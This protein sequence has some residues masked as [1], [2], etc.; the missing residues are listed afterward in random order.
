MPRMEELPEGFFM[1][2]KVTVGTQ[3]RNAITARLGGIAQ[4][5]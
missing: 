3:K 1:R 2:G 5:L 4:K